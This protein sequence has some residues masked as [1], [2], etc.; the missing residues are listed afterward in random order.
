MKSADRWALQ[1]AQ[2]MADWFLRPRLLSSN[3]LKGCQARL[4]WLL[5]PQ[6]QLE[7]DSFA[8]RRA[9]DWRACGSGNFQELHAMAEPITMPDDVEM[10]IG[11]LTSSQTVSTDAGFKIELQ[12]DIAVIITR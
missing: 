8:S 4:R 7:K 10:E 3:E 1:Y 2:G 12:V 9:E 6:W 11:T 5:R